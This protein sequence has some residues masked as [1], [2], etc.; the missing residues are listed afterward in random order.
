M[1]GKKESQHCRITDDE[2]CCIVSG[3]LILK[4]FF[5][6]IFPFS[7]FEASLIHIRGQRQRCRSHPFILC[8][9]FRFC[10]FMLLPHRLV[11]QAGV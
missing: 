3:L 4:C 8:L 7:S 9:L 2:F 11:T 1:E 10:S 6:F 5:F